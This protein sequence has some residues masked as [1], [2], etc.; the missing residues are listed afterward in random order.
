MIRPRQFGL[1]LAVAP[2]AGEEPAGLARGRARDVRPFH[3]GRGSAAF[4]EEVR[5]GSADDATTAYHD[6]HP[7]TGQSSRVCAPHGGRAK[8]RSTIGR[9]YSMGR[10]S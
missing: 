4:T 7:S 8:M 6:V 3:E 1:R 5:D 2:V 9:K 10:V